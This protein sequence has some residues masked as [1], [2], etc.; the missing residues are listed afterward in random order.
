MVAG[1]PGLPMDVSTQC[2]P[3]QMSSFFRDRMSTTS[4]EPL[5]SRSTAVCS[6]MEIGVSPATNEIPSSD[7]IGSDREHTANKNHSKSTNL[8]PPNVDPEVFH[9]LPE[10]VQRELL[11]NWRRVNGGSLA[12]G[13]TGMVGTG[14]LNASPGNASPTSTHNNSNTSSNSSSNS[15]TTT[16]AAT[17]GKG[18]SKNTLHRY[19][20]KNT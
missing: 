11:T 2:G 18:S 10:D 19:F 9:A 6:K 7:R 12:S 5:P 15:T 17:A 14:K 8:L 16:N 13:S 3:S 20:V 4:S 1:S